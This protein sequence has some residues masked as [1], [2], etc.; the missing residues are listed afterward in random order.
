MGAAQRMQK[1]ELQQQK[2]ELQREKRHGCPT[3]TT[4]QVRNK[5]VRLLKKQIWEL[6]RENSCQS[7]FGGFQICTPSCRPRQ[8]GWRDRHYV[9]GCREGGG[10]CAGTHSGQLPLARLLGGT[11]AM[12]SARLAE[13]AG[14]TRL[15]AR[16]GPA[17]NEARALRCSSPARNLKPFLPGECGSVS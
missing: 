4:A 7:N 12:P 14:R 9:W 16:C 13:V 6:Q 1:W 5:S 8:L 2:Q 3:S 15:E 11:V 10:R 17:I